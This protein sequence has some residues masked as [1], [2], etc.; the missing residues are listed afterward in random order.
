MCHFWISTKKR[1]MQNIQVVLKLKTL[2]Y[3]QHIKHVTNIIAFCIR[4][5]DL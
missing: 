4:T 3:H 5:S 2:L 1:I